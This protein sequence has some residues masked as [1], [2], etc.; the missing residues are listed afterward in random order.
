MADEQVEKKPRDYVTLVSND[1]FEFHVIRQCATVGGMT[2]RMLDP[3][4]MHSGA[5]GDMECRPA[6]DIARQ[7]H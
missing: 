1:G 6:T 2:R 4:S 7:L 3:A 5:H